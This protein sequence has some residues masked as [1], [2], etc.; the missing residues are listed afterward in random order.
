MSAGAI[1][2]DRYGELLETAGF[3]EVSIDA[4]GDTGL[5]VSANVKAR[6]P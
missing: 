3:I 5:V 6:K 4:A 1:T 2:P